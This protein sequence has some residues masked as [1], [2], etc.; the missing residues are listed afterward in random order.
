V[1]QQHLNPDLLATQTTLC[2]ELSQ[3]PEHLFG[4]SSGDSSLE[5]NKGYGKLELAGA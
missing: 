1:H 3:V 5:K 4:V 2:T